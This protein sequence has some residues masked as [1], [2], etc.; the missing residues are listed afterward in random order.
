MADAKGKVKDKQPPTA[1][2]PTTSKSEASKLDLKAQKGA[3]SDSKA[4]LDPKAQKAESDAKSKLDTKAPK[5]AASDPKAKVDPKSQNAASDAKSKL[6][7][8]GQMKSEA[9]GKLSPKE[10]KELE[11]KA[12]GKPNQQ[13]EANQEDEQDEAPQEE[14][15]YVN[16][17]KID[18]VYA[19]Y[20]EKHPPSKPWSFDMSPPRRPI[21]KPIIDPFKW[22]KKYVLPWG[23]EKVKDAETIADEERLAKLEAERLSKKYIRPCGPGEHHHKRVSIYCQ[24]HRD[25]I[26]KLDIYGNPKLDEAGNPIFEPIY[27]LNSHGVMLLDG[28]GHPVPVYILDKDGNVQLDPQGQPMPGPTYLLDAKGNAL[29]DQAGNLIQEPDHVDLLDA[30]GNVVL[31][32]H[33]LRRHEPRPV[34]MLD[35]EG[36]VMLDKDGNR[37]LG[38]PYRDVEGD[39]VMT[40]EGKPV[41]GR[42]L[43]GELDEEGQVVWNLDGD[44]MLDAEGMPLLERQET[45]EENKFRL[46][47]EEEARKA[48]AFQEKL[49]LDRIMMHTPLAKKPVPWRKYCSTMYLPRSLKTVVYKDRGIPGDDWKKIVKRYTIAEMNHRMAGQLH[50]KTGILW[51]K[52]HEHVTYLQ[53]PRYA[54]DLKQFQALRIFRLLENEEGESYD[55][56]DPH[57]LYFDGFEP[58]ST[59]TQHL[60]IYNV[61]PWT[62]R[63]RVIK[64]VTSEFFITSTE[65]PFQGKCLVSGHKCDFDVIY[66]PPTVWEYEDV[67]TIKTEMQTLPLK[68]VAINPYPIV[69]LPEFVDMGLCLS[70]HSVCYH[71]TLTSKGAGGEFRF[72]EYET[73]DDYHTTIVDPRYDDLKWSYIDTNILYIPPFLVYPR[74]FQTQPNSEQEF[75]VLFRPPRVGVY[76]YILQLITST[77]LHWE[78]KFKGTAVDLKLNLQKMEGEDFRPGQV[79]LGVSFGVVTVSHNRVKE[80]TVRSQT[81]VP[82]KFFWRIQDKHCRLD[83]EDDPECTRKTID[84]NKERTLDNLREFVAEPENGF[85]AADSETAINFRFTPSEVANY[86]QV[87]C[88]YVDTRRDFPLSS[89]LWKNFRETLILVEYKKA[90]WLADQTWSE[91]VLWGIDRSA[92]ECSDQKL[93]PTTLQE[94]VSNIDRL[95]HVSQIENSGTIFRV[96]EID[97]K[98]EGTQFEVQI[99]PKLYQFSGVLTLGETHIGYVDIVNKSPTGVIFAWDCPKTDYGV[100]KNGAYVFPQTGKIGPTSKQEIQ[101]TMKARKVGSIDLELHCMIES[102]YHKGKLPLSLKVEGHVVGPAVIISPCVLDFGLCQIDSTYS[103]TITLTNKSE[104]ADSPFKLFST[105]DTQIPFSSPF[106]EASQMNPTSVN[107]KVPVGSHLFEDELLAKPVL[108]I[109]PPPPLVTIMPGTVQKLRESQTLATDISK[110]EP[111]NATTTSALPKDTKPPTLTAKLDTYRSLS[112]PDE[113]HKPSK[114]TDKKEAKSGASSTKEDKSSSRSKEDKKTSKSTSKKEEKSSKSASEGGKEV[115]EVSASPGEPDPPVLP[116]DRT[117]CP[118]TCCPPDQEPPTSTPVIIETA[119]EFV[120]APQDRAKISRAYGEI[121]QVFNDGITDPKLPPTTL[122]RPRYA[123]LPA[124]QPFKLPSQPLASGIMKGISDLIDKKVIPSMGNLNQAELPE[125]GSKV[126]AKESIPGKESLKD[127]APPEARPPARHSSFVDTSFSHLKGLPNITGPKD[128]PNADKKVKQPFMEQ[129]GNLGSL[130][131]DYGPLGPPIYK[132]PKNVPVYEEDLRQTLVFEPEEGIVPK[133]NKSITVKVTLT[134]TICGFMRLAIICEISKGLSPTQYAIARANI[135]APEACLIPCFIDLRTKFINIPISI[136]VVIRNLKPLPACYNWNYGDRVGEVADLDVEV[137]KQR[138]EIPPR[139]EWGL[140]IKLIPRKIGPLNTVLICKVFKMINPLGL[141]L[142]AII[143]DARISYHVFRP[144]REDGHQKSGR[145]VAHERIL[146]RRQQKALGNPVEKEDPDNW[147]DP[148]VPCLDFGRRK[149]LGRA[150][151]LKLLLKNHSPIEV[152]VQLTVG[153]YTTE[154]LAS[155]VKDEAWVISSLTERLSY[156]I[157][158]RRDPFQSAF[159]M[160]EKDES[161][162]FH[163]NT[164]ALTDLSDIHLKYFSQPGKQNIWRR[165][166]GAMHEALIKEHMPLAFLC[167]PSYTGVIKPWSN[168]SVEVVCFSNLPGNYM[169]VLTSKVGRLDPV[170][171]P[172][173][174]ELIGTPLVARRNWLEPKGLQQPEE[175]GEITLVWQPLHAGHHPI[176]RQFWVRNNSPF[177]MELKWEFKKQATIEGGK[178]V[179]MN[180]VIEEDKLTHAIVTPRPEWYRDEITTQVTVKEH[181]GIVYEQQVHCVFRDY[182]ETI[183]RESQAIPFVIHPPKQVILGHSSYPFEVEFFP[184]CA[185]SYS[186]VLTGYQRIYDGNFSERRRSTQ[187]VFDSTFDRKDDQYVYRRPEKKHVCEHVVSF[188]SKKQDS[189]AHTLAHKT[190]IVDPADPEVLALQLTEDGKKPKRLSRFHCS[191]ASNSSSSSDDEKSKLQKPVKPKSAVKTF[192]NDKDDASSDLEDTGPLE[193]RPSQTILFPPNTG[194]CKISGGERKTRKRAYS[195]VHDIAYQSESE[196]EEPKYQFDIRRRSSRQRRVSVG[197]EVNFDEHS[198]D[199]EGNIYDAQEKELAGDAQVDLSETFATTRCKDFYN[200]EAIRPLRVS[201]EAVTIAPRLKTHLDDSLLERLTFQCFGNDPPDRRL[202]IQSLYLT[203]IYAHTISFDIFVPEPFKVLT[204]RHGVLQPV[205]LGDQCQRMSIFHSP[206]NHFELEAAHTLQFNIMYRPVVD[207]CLLD[208]PDIVVDLEFLVDFIDCLHEQTIPL[209]ADVFFPE[210]RLVTDTLNLGEVVTATTTQAMDFSLS[211]PSL[212]DADWRIV[213]DETHQ[214]TVALAA[215]GIPPKWD[216]SKGLAKIWPVIWS[217]N[218]ERGVVRGRRENELGVT[219]EIQFY[220]NKSAVTVS[221]APFDMVEYELAIWVEIRLGRGV[222]LTLKGAGIDEPPDLPPPTTPPRGDKKGKDKTK[223]KG[224]KKEKEEKTGKD[225]KKG[226]K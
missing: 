73:P 103:M 150:H 199:S 212:A 3:G 39:V 203:N 72:E 140:T 25:P 193:G 204:I 30:E 38:R 176:T 181:I 195:K 85:F 97:V 151:C 89:D 6:D 9:K 65:E 33:G 52:L 206:L 27:M 96:A 106:V 192:L 224:E 49:E 148:P 8:K 184:R 187:F 135:D 133:G 190:S 1:E 220:R 123:P 189:F 194:L 20:L 166:E 223:G 215:K 66:Q 213:T 137:I 147:V 144:D 173:E 174:V 209:H 134:G 114:S 71:Y 130:P 13:L 46:A 110:Q 118:H 108:P 167:Y 53:N 69:V 127:H 196:D 112:R 126:G 219:N 175:E 7:P 198:D 153:R 41:P 210:V 93:A 208:P 182:L 149:T 12:K 83:Q 211:N 51:R 164:P 17:F 214:Q 186:F 78:I 35:A 77:N 24:P 152:K 16:P 125:N 74:T 90:N 157:P 205:E 207:E 99:C 109:P 70:G 2:K 159:K 113:E 165:A 216:D 19:H 14:T 54:A 88:L 4:K 11:K 26:Y 34:Y 117:E 155:L 132:T 42:F 31:D 225:K 122:F 95:F 221:F 57:V 129:M 163:L 5:G 58:G 22:S 23:E 32:E 67:V 169:D 37:I 154:P 142:K 28:Q 68:L 158:L 47:L 15:P 48:K 18:N 177:H 82:L 160:R 218:P 145:K 45:E 55:L 217:A 100:I 202:D 80:V 162:E 139:L 185:E 111:P 87:A 94:I 119:P 104:Y 171:L 115:T 84:K 131:K 168:W 40:A 128:A 21:V 44:V 136:N 92:F 62:Q 10:Q 91:R 161:S 143:V 191:E 101:V 180:F 222:R 121:F 138:G 60:R 226:R 86:E 200:F 146:L 179:T 76:H 98:G 141:E 79:E 64:P 183:D 172:L 105:R 63:I 75:I 170:D 61:S 156:L 36:H 116:T 43:F 188:Y 59:Y 107:T 56:I 29:L 178:F 124:L 50:G 197:R 102:P 120:P 81:P 201:L